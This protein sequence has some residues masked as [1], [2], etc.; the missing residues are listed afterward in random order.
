VKGYKI[1][2]LIGSILGLIITISALVMVG[3]LINEF[4][5]NTDYQFIGLAI[6]SSILYIVALC[7]AFG[8]RNTR[9]SGIILIILAVLVLV[10]SRFYGILGFILLSNFYGILGFALLLSAG[11]IALRENK[12]PP[13]S[14]P[15]VNPMI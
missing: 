6:S 8:T 4:K 15:Q 10:L 7:V 5:L 1:L 9:V 2:T 12:P 11:V 3:F 13:G 14:V